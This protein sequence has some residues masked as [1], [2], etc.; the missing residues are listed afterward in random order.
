MLP[1][2]AAET[3][4]WLADAGLDLR[5]AEL[6]LANDIEFWKRSLFNFQQAAEKALKAT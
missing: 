1:E 4:E 5:L 6:L 2:R 3:R